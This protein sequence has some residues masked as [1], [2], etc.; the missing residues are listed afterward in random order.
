MHDERSQPASAGS[1]TPAAEDAESQT[2]G[3]VDGPGRGDDDAGL[4]ATSADR[5]GGEA[6]SSPKD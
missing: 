4:G 2:E 6:T 5:P 1:P 3:P